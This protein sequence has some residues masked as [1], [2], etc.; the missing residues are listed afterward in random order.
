MEDGVNWDIL[1]ILIKL[2]ILIIT[3]FIYIMILKRATNKRDALT[4]LGYEKEKGKGTG[5]LM[6]GFCKIKKM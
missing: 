2:M 5:N 4:M 3:N 1:Y 6:W